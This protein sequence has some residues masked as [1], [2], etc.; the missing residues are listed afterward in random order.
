MGFALSGCVGGAAVS[1]EGCVWA[2]DLPHLRRESEEGSKDGALGRE[3]VRRGRG[4]QQSRDG[5]KDRKGQGTPQS[6]LSRGF[7]ALPRPSCPM[8]TSLPC[9]PF[10]KSPRSLTDLI[11]VTGGGWIV[12][13]L[14]KG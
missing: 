11:L 6:R 9:K 12:G 2:G 10:Q 13:V 5:S 3:A 4:G 14:R 8:S 1:P 7:R